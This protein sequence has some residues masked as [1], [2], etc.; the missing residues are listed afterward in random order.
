MTL[1]TTVSR[2]SYP[3]TG[4][5][6]PFAYPFSINVETDLL[7]T[8]RSVALV[9]TTL[10]WP[11]D[12]TV[13][14]V[15]N[16]SGTITLT[17]ALA[18][19]ESIFI[20]RAPPLTQPMSIRNQ[21][22]YFPATIEDEIDRLTMQL[23]DLR[24]RVDRSVKL[25][26][27]VSGAPSLTEMEPTAGKVVAG[28]GT[29]FTM[30]SL[31]SSAV[32][33]PGGGRTVTTLS[34]YLANNAVWNVKDFGAL[35]DGASDD[36]AKIIATIAAAPNGATILFPA[37]VTSY[38]VTGPVPITGRSKLTLLGLSY[39]AKITVSANTFDLFVVDITSDR[40]TIDGLTLVGASSALEFR[41][42]VV[43]SA[44]RTVVRNCEISGF[45]VG[46]YFW[47]ANW[48]SGWEFCKAIDNYI[49]DLFGNTSGNG[50]GVY[51]VCPH[52]IIARNRFENVPRHDAYCSGSDIGAN[53]SVVEGNVSSGSTVQAIAIYQ[54]AGYPPLTGVTVHGNTVR[55]CAIGIRAD[56]NV[57]SITITGN[58]VDNASLASIQLDGGVNANEQLQGIIISGNAIHASA[59][60]QPIL[61]TNGSRCI[62]TGNSIHSSGKLYGIYITSSGS[63]AEF[64]TGNQVFNNVIWGNTSNPIYIDPT[65]VDTIIG[66]NYATAFATNI[67]ND[68]D[69]ITYVATGTP[70]AIDLKGK[71]DL[72]R[73]IRIIF[74]QVG[75]ITVSNFI[76]AREGQEL[77][78]YFQTASVVTITNANAF[79]VGGAAS[80]TSTSV[81][82]IKFIL[83]GTNWIET[84]RS[85]N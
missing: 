84:G 52:S 47:V 25:K 72:G 66:T 45:N 68:R 17:T 18:S 30:S 27:T 59:F 2:T 60:D 41:R 12:F 40:I 14:G 57:W 78:C 36:L 19:G 28:T 80:F 22:S 51:T 77:I 50:Y 8:K 16:A 38:R 55:N 3:G 15:K 6:G 13:T 26:E 67:G 9:E 11:I 63:P 23:Q 56:V 31:D 10:V 35:G 71:G 20:R 73:P 48:Y 82:I 5:T 32:A 61:I 65:C 33:L 54:V 62:I 85:V 79:F 58:I 70:V 24:D 4:S 69:V 44:T 53:Y 81:D 75:A 7:V 37:V 74:N 83:R 49:H 64:P 46:V 29:G 21:G 76:N 34:A 43:S 42:A 39:G 1:A